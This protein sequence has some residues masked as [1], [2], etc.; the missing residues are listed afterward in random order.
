MNLPGRNV[1]SRFVIDRYACREQPN[2]FP[3][4]LAFTIGDGRR[5]PANGPVRRS[6]FPRQINQALR[7]NFNKP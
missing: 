1:V 3:E 5:E 4:L 7:F 6:P 2:Y